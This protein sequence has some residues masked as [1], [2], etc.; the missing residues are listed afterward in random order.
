MEFGFIKFFSFDPS[1]PFSHFIGKPWPVFS[2]RLQDEYSSQ[3]LEVSEVLVSWNFK[4][5][6]YTSIRGLG[7]YPHPRSKQIACRNWRCTNKWLFFWFLKNLSFG[8]LKGWFIRK[9][10][11]SWIICKSFPIMDFFL[12]NRAGLFHRKTT[13][14]LIYMKLFNVTL[15][16]EINNLQDFRTCLI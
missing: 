13:I 10:I 12:W 2:L 8:C 16:I 14:N 3:S 4:D 1:G 9:A 5:W 7:F 6:S 11:S 15:N